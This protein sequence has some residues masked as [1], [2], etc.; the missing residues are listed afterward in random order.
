MSWQR[1]AS[2]SSDPFHLGLCRIPCPFASHSTSLGASTSASPFLPKGEATGSRARNNFCFIF[3]QSLENSAFCSRAT[4]LCTSQLIFALSKLSHPFLIPPTFQCPRSGFH[5]F[6]CSLPPVSRHPRA[7]QRHSI[8]SSRTF[9][10]PKLLPAFVQFVGKSSSREPSHRHPRYP[11][12]KRAKTARTAKPIYR[13]AARPLSRENQSTSILSFPTPSARG[14]SNPH[15]VNRAE[16]SARC[17]QASCPGLSKLSPQSSPPPSLS[18]PRSGFLPVLVDSL[19]L[20]SRLSMSAKRF[21]CFQ[22]NLPPAH[23]PHPSCSLGGLRGLCVSH[24]SSP[25]PPRRGRMPHPR[26]CSS[27]L[28]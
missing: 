16:L 24:S 13:R 10:L 27:R 6:Q 5:V 19:P 11:V 12:P 14:P 28:A 15:P 21:S 26:K 9:P 25:H 3:F 18:C 1:Y 17:P 22:C 8:H 7:A 20:S 23:L 4:R 2:I